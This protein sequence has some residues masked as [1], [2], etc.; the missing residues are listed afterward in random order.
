MGDD[1]VADLLK[2]AKAP[3]YVRLGWKAKKGAIME[4]VLAFL[5]A[6]VGKGWKRI[7]FGVVFALLL[8]T[9]SAAILFGVQI[10]L[11]DSALRLVAGYLS[12]ANPDAPVSLDQAREQWPTIIAAF[13]TGVAG[14]VALLQPT[15][16][17][18]LARKAK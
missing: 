1:P 17:W 5:D 4:A 3:W 12:T 13:T 16:R 7:A 6:K 8:V 10:P 14:V 18:L 9:Q 15:L 11:F 2:D